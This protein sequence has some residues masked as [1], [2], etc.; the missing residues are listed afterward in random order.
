VVTFSLRAST[1]LRVLVGVAVVL[2]LLSAIS[3][4][5]Y[6]GWGRLGRPQAAL[7][8]DREGNVPTWWS[9]FQVGLLALLCFHLSRRDRGRRGGRPVAWLLCGAA[10]LYVSV[11]EVAQ[12]H[13]QLN[14]VFHDLAGRSDGIFRFGWVFL[15]LPVVAVFVVVMFPLLLSLPRPV[16]AELLA[17]GAVF[18]LG[19]VALEVVGS[20]LLSAG[21]SRTS[22]PFVLEYHAE[23]FFEMTGVAVA[24]HAVARYAA[25]SGERVLHV[26]AGG[27]LRS[28]T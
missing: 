6:L 5:A 7:D 4:V 20:A 3:D 26:P 15:A 18:L 27:E 24:F 14:A 23:E 9:S 16:A 25:S 22:F 2:L 21:W 8:L 1:V 11:D 19:A 10:L 17:G 13:E 28:R 12:L